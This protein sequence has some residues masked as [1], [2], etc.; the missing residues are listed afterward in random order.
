M[1][2][3]SDNETYDVDKDVAVRSVLINNMMEG[4]LPFPAILPF[5]SHSLYDNIRESRRLT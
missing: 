5:L 3:A 4:E 2:A 1:C